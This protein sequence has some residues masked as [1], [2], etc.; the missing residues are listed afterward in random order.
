MLAATM[1]RPTWFLATYLSGFAAMSAAARADDAGKIIPPEVVQVE[2]V[3]ITDEIKYVT[4]GNQMGSYLLMCN[5]HVDG[6]ITPEPGASYYLFNK[7]TYWKMPGAKEFIDL[8]WV[9]DW[10][11][12]YNQAENVA[13][14]PDVTSGAKAG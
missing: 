6:C 7:N 9:Q 10:T 8:K 3:N 2:A 11:A 5:I 13:L 1:K 4:I 12:T 14:V